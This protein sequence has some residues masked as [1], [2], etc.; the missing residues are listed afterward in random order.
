MCKLKLIQFQFTSY[1]L[2]QYVYTK[3]CNAAITY[4]C[5][6]FNK[7]EQEIRD[8][9]RSHPKGSDYKFRAVQV[10]IEFLLSRGFTREDIFKDMHIILYPL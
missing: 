3:K 4:L 5:C 6:E 1:F 8:A 9:L 7:T 10:N 2:D